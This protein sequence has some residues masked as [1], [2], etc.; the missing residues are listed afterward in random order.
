VAEDVC[1]QDGQVIRFAVRVAPGLVRLQPE[2]LQGVHRQP[3]E[4]AAELVQIAADTTRLAHA[5]SAQ[6]S[7]RGLVPLQACGAV[8]PVRR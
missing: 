4:L 5:V 8:S 3:G 1:G 2:V 6:V 7:V